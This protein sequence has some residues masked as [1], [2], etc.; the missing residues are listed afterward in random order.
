ML[1]YSTKD[2]VYQIETR[3]VNRQEMFFLMCR[4]RSDDIDQQVSLDEPL[5]IFRISLLF[6]RKATKLLRIIAEGVRV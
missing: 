4:R 6:L 3:F 1:S 2:E 5:L